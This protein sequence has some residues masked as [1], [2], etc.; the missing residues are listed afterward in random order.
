M[1]KLNEIK[2]KIE[3]LI[4]SKQ[5]ESNT[6]EVRNEIKRG[7]DKILGEYKI[8]ES[9]FDF[10]DNGK[11]SIKLGDKVFEITTINKGGYPR[12]DFK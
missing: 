4:T 1:E 9:N 12:T 8:D 7:V 2:S 6:P 11:M 3:K 10:I 5:W